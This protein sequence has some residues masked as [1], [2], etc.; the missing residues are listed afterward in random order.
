[1][2]LRRNKSIVP[3]LM[4]HSVGL[5]RHAWAWSYISESIESFEAK[6]AKLKQQGFSGVFWDELY[7]HMAGRTVLPDNSI[8]LTFDD[9]Y[10]DNWTTVF[11]ILKKY[12][13]KATI[14]VTPDFVDPSDEPR[15]AHENQAAAAAGFLSWAEMREMEKSGLI[16]I[17]SHAMTHTWYFAG[18]KIEDFHRP[19]DVTPY[20]WLFWNARLDRKP[21]YL[22]EDQ[23]QFLPWGYPI[24]QHAKSLSVRR[25]FPDETAMH[26]ITS[27]VSSEGDQEFFGRQDWRTVLEAHVASTIGNDGIAGYY[28][29]EAERT[30]RIRDELQRSK[31]IIETNLDKQV[32]YICWPGGANDELVQQIARDV[33][34][35]SWTLSSS[36]ALE[37]RNL[38][39]ADPETIK[40][41]G[42]TNSITVRGK[43]C[44]FGGPGLQVLKIFSHQG[45]ALHSMALKARKLVAL[46]TRPGM[47]A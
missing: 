25:F 20:P 3:A 23:Q 27:F 8:L 31:E 41:I 29:S 1:M 32:D 15:P 10:L 12:G 5:E 7:D 18:P 28:E 42:T 39:G 45:S 13:M 2:S 36:S 4:F 24:L 43:H 33:G 44:G 37:K 30:S 9:G 16:D 17:Q 26:S 34:Y 35:K 19:H 14:F 47:K 6:I 21:F 22:N 46:A 40:R 11:P 38:P